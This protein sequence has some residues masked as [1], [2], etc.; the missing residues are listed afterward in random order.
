MCTMFKI[1][2]R[3][4]DPPTDVR[5]I[6]GLQSHTLDSYVPMED[7]EALK[8]YR[9]YKKMRRATGWRPRRFNDK[10]GIRKDLMG[11][12]IGPKPLDSFGSND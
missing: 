1:Y 4:T 7:L 11:E 5:R 2:M 8:T 3:P 12:W 10:E 9:K 6:D